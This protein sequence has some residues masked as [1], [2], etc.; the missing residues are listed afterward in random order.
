MAPPPVPQTKFRFGPA[1]SSPSGQQGLG[2]ASATVGQQKLGAA[3]ANV[4]ATVGQQK[5]EAASANV[6]AS[7]ASPAAAPIVT[8]LPQGRLGAPKTPEPPTPLAKKGSGGNLGRK[9]PSSEAKATQERRRYATVTMQVQSL[10]R[11][12]KED[13]DWQRFDSDSFLKGV[14]DAQKDLDET[15]A[16]SKYFRE[17]MLTEKKELAKDFDMTPEMYGSLYA[18]LSP[19]ISKL[20]RE[21]SGVMSMKIA[22]QNALRETENK[23][24]SAPSKRRRTAQ[25]PKE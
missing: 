7:A 19:K 6:E 1:T 9:E 2:A 11:A 10:Q 25:A 12:L 24:K 21:V 17:F 20:Q 16:S 15:I 14:Q 5:L 13:A 23:V 3:S 4:E 22:R 18:A 8:P